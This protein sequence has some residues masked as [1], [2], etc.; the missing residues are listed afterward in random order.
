MKKNYIK[1]DIELIIFDYSAVATATG[2]LGIDSEREPL[3][4]DDDEPFDS[5]RPKSL[6]RSFAPRIESEGDYDDF[7]EMYADGEV[8]DD[9]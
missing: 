5:A 1:P 2:D 6:F 3:S 9:Y 7:D 8:F 4:D